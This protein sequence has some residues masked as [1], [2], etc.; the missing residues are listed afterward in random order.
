MDPFRVGQLIAG[1][2]RI[3]EI[4]SLGPRAHVYAVSHERFVDV[5]LVLKTVPLACTHDFARDTA[6]LGSLTT[7]S[8]A[9][10][11]DGGTLPDGRPFRVVTR[12]KGPM[13]DAALST[14]LFGD[15]R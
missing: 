7:P 12:L 4:L 5:P 6:A 14:A 8:L 2:Y 10:M 15:A 3:E 1:T 13:L 11:C 9:R